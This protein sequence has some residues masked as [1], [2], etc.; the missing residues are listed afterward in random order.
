MLLI[1]VN[2]VEKIFALWK[3]PKLKLSN[4]ISTKETYNKYIMIDYP[5]S[6][7]KLTHFIIFLYRNYFILWCFANVGFLFRKISYYWILWITV[8]YF[9]GTFYC[10]FR[11]L[12]SKFSQKL[13]H[14]TNTA[15]DRNK[16]PLS[17]TRNLPV[18]KF[19]YLLN[20]I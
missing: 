14:E 3:L 9:C 5:C 15:N 11:V 2:F 10:H 17:A 19:K 4:G 16:F 12:N 18:I 7:F 8:L 13:K 20:W 1:L 6:N